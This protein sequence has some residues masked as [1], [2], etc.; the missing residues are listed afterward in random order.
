MVWS[1]SAYKTFLQKISDGAD[2]SK[3]EVYMID[4]NE[5]EDLA[6]EFQIKRVLHFI[7][8]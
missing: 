4:I 2:S 6:N 7:Y 1:M 8:T 3:L 5:N